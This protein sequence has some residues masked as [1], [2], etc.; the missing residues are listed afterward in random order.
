MSDGFYSGPSPQ[1]I[2]HAGQT[3]AAG[4]NMVYDKLN[5][6][7][8]QSQYLNAFDS[9]RKGMTD[10][11]GRLQTNPN[12]HEYGELA[13]QNDENLYEQIDKSIK[14]P[15]AR[16]QFA[17]SY[18]QM[19]AQHYAQVSQLAVQR[20][21]GN[22]WGNLEG[23][24]ERLPN[25][26]TLNDGQKRDRMKNILSRATLF[27]AWQQGELQR[28]VDMLSRQMD[29]G[30]A[31]RAGY[32]VLAKTGDLGQAWSQ[33]DQTDLND[34]EKNT[35]K[36]ELKTQWD[37]YQ[38]QLVK[39][40]NDADEQKV[41][42]DY[43]A[44]DSGRF[45]F[46]AFVTAKGS[47]QG[48]KGAQYYRSVTEYYQKSI[49]EMRDPSSAQLPSDPSAVSRAAAIADD[50]NM[51]LAD[52]TVAIHGLQGLS[53][54]DIT[55]YQRRAATPTTEAFKKVASDLQ[56]YAKATATTKP[57]SPQQEAQAQGMLT[58]LKTQEN[59]QKLN[60]RQI[61]DEG[62]RIRKAVDDSGLEQAITDHFGGQRRFGLW[63]EAGRSPEAEATNL[64][65]GLMPGGELQGLQNTGFVRGALAD[66][67]TYVDQHGPMTV[68]LRSG[69]RVRVVLSQGVLQFEEAK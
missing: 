6:V 55:L 4:M 68:T 7:E 14:N 41:L 69:K 64:L 16:N 51:S 10:F 25:D 1:S 29:V 49:R 22:L 2:E 59:I 17:Q 62:S 60:P 66:L 42:N 27:P 47:F 20:R 35:V 8:A 36:R 61:I 18:M 5:Q 44:I 52:K 30:N 39:Q 67:A 65:N 33:V 26:N 48:D 34:T 40:R 3:V 57:W 23:E 43:S 15:L 9:M 56:A 53:R 12:W 37:Q 45:D 31:Y 54:G 58:D 11:D 13:T 32:G 38:A 46:G 63:W 21:L 19:K 24:L 50:T 28:Q